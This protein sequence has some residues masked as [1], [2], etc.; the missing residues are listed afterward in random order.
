M[1]VAADVDGDGNQEV[2]VGG[3]FG[4]THLFEGDGSLR[5]TYA[6]SGEVAATFTTSGAFGRFGVGLAYAQPGTDGASLVDSLLLPGSGN[7]IKNVERAFSAAAGAPQPGF[8]AALQGLDFLGAPIITDVTGDGAPEI[9]NA[10]DSSALHG[11]TTRGA[12]ATGFP[13]FF[14]GWSLWSP[15]AGDLDA[16]GRTELVMLSRE[17]YLFVWN[18]PGVS[19]G[20]NEWWHSG[21]DE[22]NTGRY[23]ADTRPPGVIRNPSWTGGPSATFTAPGDDWY[24]GT[25]AKYVVTYQ[26]S[27]STVAVAPSGAAGSTQTIGVPAGTT[28]F[29]VR[30]VDDAGNSARPTT[31]TRS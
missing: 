2:A 3:A 14:T 29:T 10:G 27:S 13:K 24:T 19:S 23:G 16:S 9:I 4:P 11:Y 22:R 31:V 20:N 30:A 7:P 12:Q 25:V 18:T 6:G 26:P 17:G 5:L 1:P 28:S 21:H 15:S 8:P